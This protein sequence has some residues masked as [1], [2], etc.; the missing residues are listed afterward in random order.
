MKILELPAA[1]AL[2]A[3]ITLLGTVKLGQALGGGFPASFKGW[4][5]TS[6]PGGIVGRL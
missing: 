4:Q 1:L 6:D 5:G 3:L 2:L